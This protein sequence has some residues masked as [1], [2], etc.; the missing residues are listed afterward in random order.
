MFQ[1]IVHK[2][3]FPIGATVG[4]IQGVTNTKRLAGGHLPTMDG[5]INI[6]PDL[7]P[8]VA[9]LDMAHELDLA[10]WR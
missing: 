4:V 6:A 9:R 1:K 5:T 8:Q 3:L 7:H 10:T 2:S